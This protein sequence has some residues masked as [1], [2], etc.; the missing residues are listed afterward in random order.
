M[1]ILLNL[2]Y[3]PSG[4]GKTDYIYNLILDDLKAEKK[5][6][7]IVPDQYIYS[8][9]SKFADLTDNISA[10]E[11]DIL[12]FRRLANHVFREEGGLSFSDIDDSGRLLVMWRVLRESA[13][14]L[15]T[16]CNFD[17][18]ISSFAELMLNTI[19]ELKQFSI[20]PVMLENASKKLDNKYSDLKNKLSDIS[21]IYG[22][23]QSF[24]SNEYNDPS[25]EL[26]RLVDVLENSDMFNGYNVY[27][28][29]F[30]GFTPQQYS[31]LSQL[32]KKSNN[33]FLSLC[34]D[35]TDNTGVFSTTEKTYKNFQ[36]LGNRLGID[37]SEKF[38]G[39][40]KTVVNEAISFVSRNFWN[41]K[42]G[43]CEFIGDNTNV[44]TFSCHDKFEECE[45]LASDILKKVRKGA[46]YRDFVVIA[47]D[48]NSYDGIIDAEFE[49]NG[50]PFY[51]S[52]RTDLS[53]KPIFK[54]ILAAFSIYNKNWQYN[55]VI[56][57][58]KTGLANVSYDEI[59]V[60]EN[61]AST[62]NINGRRWIDGIDWN[63]NPDGFTERITPEGR[64]IINTA[65]DIR[66]RI[67][68]PLEKLFDSIHNST[69]T[70]I[71]T[72][73]YNLLTELKVVEQIEKQIE[74]CH[75]TGQLTE[76]K[77]LVQL[78]NIL[79]S[80]LDMIV[81]LAGDMKL[82]ADEYVTLISLILGRS[83]IGTIPSSLDQV[84]LGSASS[85]R[86]DKVKH[87]YL[88]GVNEGEFPKLVEENAIFTDIEKNLLRS[89][90]IDF[91]PTSE[92]M[93]SD[94]LYWFYKALS[95]ATESLTLSYAE[96]DLR[97]SSNKISVAGSRIHYILNKDVIKYSDI[98]LIDKIEGKSTAIKHYAINRNNEEGIALREYFSQDEKMNAVIKS[99]DTPLATG[100]CNINEDVA[101]KL[102]KGDMSTSQSR[103]DSYV[104][105][106]FS[107]HCQY[108]LKL[109]EKKKSV[110]R[111]N[112]I[113][114]FV[115]AILER[116]ISQIS[117]ED[118]LNTDIDDSVVES[119]VD[120]IIQDYILSV[121]QGMS[122]QCPRMKMLIKRLRRTTL[123]LIRNILSEFRQSEFV[124]TFFELPI[125]S[126]REDGISPYEIE[127]DDGSKLY[128]RG[129][130]DRVDTYKKGNDVYI[131]VVDYK[132]STK[133]FSMDDVEKGLNLQMLLYL[134]AIWN[135]KED[136]FKK[137]IK[138]EGDILPA[139]V[140]YYSAIAPTVKI[141]NDTSFSNVYSDALCN[142]ERNGLLINDIDIL[143]AM[144]KELNGLY[145]PAKIKKDG[146]LKTS[147][148]LQS[149]EEF[150]Q[151]VEKIDGI[152]KGIANNMKA[153]IV[154]A[155][156]IE[157]SKDKTACTYCKMKPICR[158]IEKGD[159]DE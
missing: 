28:D 76:E 102:Y 109:A 10:F 88:I 12:G 66:N 93:T 51:M 4:C 32:I 47:R 134:F 144:D 99:F 145:I 136:W 92:E 36:K 77:E 16:Y 39:E 19:N 5:A 50:I 118:G 129:Y 38:I 11:L 147:D 153:G 1:N 114:S 26:T 59:D 65:N 104:N 143:R 82:S 69:V 139:G 103:I 150:G 53:T 24:I 121:C 154:D 17:K 33:T 98:P 116:F 125:W 23:Y 155:K 101:N 108:I 29:G 123:L 20:T 68:P 34:F 7:L 117:G 138:C 70:E 71:T 30:D 46:N 73:V 9:E 142:I 156:P 141:K 25:D 133:K 62:W 110:F 43:K 83:D 107:Y 81:E 126:D 2:I 40:N 86:T 63:M 58:L 113:G 157:I 112:D 115:H 130:V 105:C 90:D 18:N 56:S 146:T 85:L 95:R 79:I 37:I 135:A 8:A 60:L 21:F 119:M 15:K 152:L 55:D 87:V 41:H 151:L 128:M 94:E 137:K 124:P 122:E 80:S 54:L 131:R 100:Q 149:L 97:G 42:V 48:I 45:F 75:S 52:K 127:L 57:Y 22:T 106:A 3:G 14:F 84:I 44:R 132:T 74:E 72:A 159:F 78:W 27:I 31:V 61:Y 13:P 111:G 6:V 49:N 35:P 120:N 96:S 140:L 89:V 91:T 148:S 67:T 64:N 158:R